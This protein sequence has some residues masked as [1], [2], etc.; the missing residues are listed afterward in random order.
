MKNCI[1]KLICIYYEKNCIEESC[2]R[3]KYLNGMFKKEFI[4]LLNSNNLEKIL[5]NIEE[6]EEKKG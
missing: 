1:Y 6:K 4:D 3:A 5:K 2:W